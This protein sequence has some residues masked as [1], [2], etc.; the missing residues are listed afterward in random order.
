MFHLFSIYVSID[1]H[2][3]CFHVLATA[4]NGAIHLGMHMSFPISILGVV[5]YIYPEEE[6]LGP[7]LPYFITFV[8]KSILSDTSIATSALFPFP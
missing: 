6:L 2:T 3:G 5:G 4:G 1:E 7:S 8:L